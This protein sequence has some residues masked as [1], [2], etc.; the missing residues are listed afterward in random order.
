MK[1]KLF[2]FMFLVSFGLSNIYAGGFQIN[3]HGARAMGLGGA[4][5][6]LAND[7]SA[8]YFNP[9]GIIQLS[10]THFMIGTTMISPDASFRGVYPSVKE[11]NLE[12]Q[13]FFPSHFFAT[14]QIDKDWSVGLG[15]T[16][17]F[18]LGTKWD[19]DWVGRYLAVQ[20]DLMT[21]LIS[22][23]VAYK[24]LD[25]LSVSAGFEYS[26]ANVTIK[27]KQPQ[28]P[29]AGDAFI[30]LDGKDNSAFGYN[31][32]FLYKP[33][34]TLSIGASYHSD[35][36]YDFKGTASTEGAQQLKDAGKLPEG[37]VIAKL[38]TPVNFTVGMAYNIYSRLTVSADF[39]YIGW[40][41]YDTLKVDFENPSYTDINSPRE[42]DN[43]YIVRLG[44]EYQFT[45]SLAIQG[46]IYFDSNP[47][48]PKYLNPSLPDADRL[49]FSL[50]IDY[51]LTKSLGV[52][53]A[54]L[55]I[56]GQQLTVDNSNESYSSGNAPF[57]GTYN[58]S[59]NLLSLSLSYSL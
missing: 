27:Q 29:F 16:T 30:T 12:K 18:G 25:N 48:K 50:G 59:A 9:A 23:V 32:G 35:I 22:P 14:H 34:K 38:T 57:N 37:N 47:V 3:E 39:Q 13:T 8:V 58:T 17:P 7:A 42:Y 44:G 24:I 45:N 36:K 20:T 15:F 31:F 33:F 19:S 43:S 1:A 40:S 52:N 56:R 54:Y 49:G 21:F 11:Y 28:T 10:G 46:G 51:K 53:L 6:A 41:S 26:F 2:T 5:T 4:F 55:F